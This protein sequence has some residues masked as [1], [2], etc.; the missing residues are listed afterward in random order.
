MRK[1]RVLISII[2]G[3]ILL[4][5]ISCERM[6]GGGI[7]ASL[8]KDN[9]TRYVWKDSGGIIRITEEKP[10]KEAEL[11]R[12]INDGD[13][14]RTMMVETSTLSLPTPT[15]APKSIP[16]DNPSSIPTLIPT[17]APTIASDTT[18]PQVILLTT[19]W[20]IY[21]KK[22]RDFFVKNNIPFTEYDTEK[23]AEGKRLFI[24]H[25]GRGVPLII[26]DGQAISGFNEPHIRKLL[27]IS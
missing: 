4:L 3:F 8:G 25:N 14:T 1:T 18:K 17:T 27:T 6:S 13:Q 11:I 23:T 16:R 12:T 21:C 7:F 2:L 9:S 26:I 20:C 15:A 10:P 24:K 5:S 22:A 19:T